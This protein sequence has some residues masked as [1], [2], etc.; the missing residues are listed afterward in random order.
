M[1]DQ[2]FYTE[3]GQQR[4][5]ITDADLKAL[6]SEGRLAKED[7]IWKPGMPLWLPAG[8][9]RGIF[10][11]RAAE[12]PVPLAGTVPLATPIHQSGSGR[13]GFPQAPMSQAARRKGMSSGA[14]IAIGL[15][16]AIVLIVFAGGA[17]IYFATRDSSPTSQMFHIHLQEGQR[18]ARHVLLKRNV[19][20]VVT[21]NSDM[22]TDVDLH[23]FDQRGQQVASDTRPDRNCR[24]QFTPQRTEQY[25]LEIVNLPGRGWNRCRMTVEQGK[26]RR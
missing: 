3:Q 9:A 18:E 16:L 13:P 12:L 24:V 25:R 10:P 11:D 21:V 8:Q 4:G 26:N 17:V 1:A 5:P 20:V 6:A 19:P 7:L 15:G 23:V 2:W 14:K 22:D